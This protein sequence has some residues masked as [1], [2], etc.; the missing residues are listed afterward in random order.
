MFKAELPLSFQL[1][2]LQVGWLEKRT[3]LNSILL[4]EEE[5]GPKRMNL[6]LEETQEEQEEFCHGERGAQALGKGLGL[7]AQRLLPLPSTA[8]V[9][10]FRSLPPQLS[11]PFVHLSSFPSTPHLQL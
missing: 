4:E 3:W 9:L 7:G 10:P 5:S 8:V 1:E 2:S 6:M 11:P